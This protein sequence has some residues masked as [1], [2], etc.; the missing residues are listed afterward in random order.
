MTINFKSLHIYH[1][2]SIEEAIIDLTNRGFCLVNG[3]NK[4][5]KDAARSNGS[6]KSSIWNALCFVLTGETISGLKTNLANINFN[7]GCYVELEFEI[8]NIIYKLIRSKDDPTLGTNLKIYINGEDKS[9]KGI[10]ESQALLE[11]Y[12][13]D[14]TKELV[15]SVILLGQGLP[16]RFTS[17]T[18]SGRKEVLEHLSKSDFMI[19]D[20][21]ERIAARL[22][23]LNIKLREL[24][25][26]LLIQ[27]SQQE[28]YD[29][30]LTAY[31]ATL[32]KLSTKI[33]FNSLIENKQQEVNNLKEVL[34][35]ALAEQSVL[36]SQKTALNS[37]LL[38]ELTTK[39]NRLAT[40]Q[41]QYTTYDKELSNKTI[42]LSTTALQLKN[43]ITELKSIKDICPT[44]GQ[45]IPNVIK[46]DT[47][48][49][50]AELE[51]LEDT[52]EDLKLETEA[53]N[54]E[55]AAVKKQIE[56]LYITATSAINKE[57]QGLLE[58]E[59]KL[60]VDDLNKEIVNKST[61]LTGLIK[62]RD[63]HEAQLLET[64]TNIKIVSEKLSSIG[65]AITDLTNALTLYKQHLEVVQKMNN[66]IKRDFRGILLS[67]IIEYINL[68]AKEYCLKIFNTDEI[69]FELDGNNIN[70][71][72]CNKDYENLS[73]GEKQRID[74]ITQFAIRDMMSKYLNFSSNILVLDEITDNLDNLSCDKVINFITEELKDVESIFIISHHKNLELPYDSEITVEKDSFGNSRII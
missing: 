16:D 44:C 19:Q 37:K 28:I 18:P 72:Y 46:P 11:E 25:D 50:E 43:K 33:D 8:D 26:S 20:L 31:T 52:L 66:S 14:L 4:N 7:N 23:T 12:L 62:D 58:K 27:K 17:N 74:I 60:K 41:S 57:L 6:G 38:E 9:G 1:F 47:S 73:G 49:Q 36:N 21:K 53:N 68:K 30:Q 51:K 2:L 45:K 15:T 48:S 13:P 22:D 64:N 39:T 63:S 55:Y 10:R 5:P 61:E 70:I 42:E 34:K 67:H 24:E 35:A 3:I 71:S 65:A 69:K 40:V 56:D 29:G 59:S 32:E 54:A